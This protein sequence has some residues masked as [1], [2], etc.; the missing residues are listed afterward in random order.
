M[1]TGTTLDLPIK[2]TDKALQ[3]IK[4][5]GQLLGV[6]QDNGLRIGVKKEGAHQKKILGFD[7]KRFT[8]QKYDSNGVVIFIDRREL[9]H[10]DHF[11]LDF[12]E[13]ASGKGFVFRETKKSK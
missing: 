6:G 9:K 7:T 10:F 13:T 5:Y 12:K 11:Y 2:I 4:E 8:D 1:T 3:K